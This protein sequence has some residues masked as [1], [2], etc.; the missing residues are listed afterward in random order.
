MS[1]LLKKAVYSLLV[2]LG[3]VV[4]VFTMFQGLGDPAR[5]M[6]GQTGDK[7]TMDNIRSELYLEQ[8]KWKQFVLY[9]D[10]VSPICIHT[11]EDIEHKQLKGLFI[12]GDTKPDSYRV[13]IK[14]PYLRKSY[15]TK[16]NVSTV[17]LNALPGT[18]LLAV[19][20]M[21][22]AIVV[23]ILLGLLMMWLFFDQLWS[24]P[25]AVE[26]RKTFV[27]TLRLLAR[28]TREPAS[29][30]VRKA[31]EE[32]YEIRDTINAH[33]DRIRS[34]WIDLRRIDRQIETHRRL[35]RRT[36]RPPRHNRL[37]RLRRNLPL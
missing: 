32:S 8:P 25:A 31:I 20:A 4:L 6:V 35:I 18:I 21:L 19:A 28:L 9:L 16:K 37:R 30:D 7:K 5:L 1:I 33:F 34:L 13:G 3:V 24:T 26:M 22:F 27:S 12:G 10:D 14:F 36:V 2:L 29:E 17:L 15:Q 23:G 11:K